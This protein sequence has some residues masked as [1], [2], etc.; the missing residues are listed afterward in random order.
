MSDRFD[1]VTESAIRDG[2]ATDAYF[3][4]T[5]ET[6]EA[7]DRNPRVVAEVTQDQFPTGE[8]DLLAGLKDAARLL[9]GLPVDVDAMREGRLFD[10]GPVLTIEGRYRDFARY[11]TSLLGFLSHAAGG[12]AGR[13]RLDGAE[14]RR[15][16][17]PPV[18]RRDDR[19]LGPAR[20]TGRLLARRR[21]RGAG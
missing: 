10:G 2:T 9:E 8:F 1:V 11:E 20:G 19:A 7:A 15:A 5:E 6:L 4:R 18:H 17:R 12:A 14:L 13:L 21:R 16:T 3:L